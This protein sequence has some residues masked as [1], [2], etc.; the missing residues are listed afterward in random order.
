V[1]SPP[2]HIPILGSNSA[3]G[4]PT[5]F[6]KFF[7]NALS[8]RDE[9]VPGGQALYAD[10]PAGVRLHKKSRSRCRWGRTQW[11]HSL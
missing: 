1:H 8:K 5:S 9:S 6:G 4:L 2:N 10:R 11:A 3:Q 7:F